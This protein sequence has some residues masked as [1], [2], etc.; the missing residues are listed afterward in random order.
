VVT[1]DLRPI[2]D[3]LPAII[4]EGIADV[5]ETL[6]DRR[7]AFEAGEV[8]GLA[9][10]HVSAFGL[11]IGMQG[12]FCV[13][14]ADGREAQR[15]D[16]SKEHAAQFANNM[17]DW[18][19]YLRETEFEGPGYYDFPHQDDLMI[20]GPDGSATNADLI[21]DREIFDAIATLAG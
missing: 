12:L 1:V 18:R 11:Y 7:T 9:D 8:R 21:G 4:E 6:E 19:W 5:L 20:I 10:P 3:Q 17:P 2:A 13:V 16:V 14:Q 15:S